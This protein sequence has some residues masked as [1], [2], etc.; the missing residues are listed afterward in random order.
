MKC[1][2]VSLCKAGDGE[3]VGARESTISPRGAE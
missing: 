1:R 3:S 2:D